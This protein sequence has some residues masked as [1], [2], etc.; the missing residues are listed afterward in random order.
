M[1][2]QKQIPVKILE[3]LSMKNFTATDLQISLHL[4]DRVF[5]R[6]INKLIDLKYTS[7]K[8]G[9]YYITPSGK[10]CI[11]TCNCR[12]IIWDFAEM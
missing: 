10:S 3:L 1:D 2:P 9:S 6:A 8:E 5:I 4:T 12:E 7:E 11:S